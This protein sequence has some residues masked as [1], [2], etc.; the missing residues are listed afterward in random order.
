VDLNLEIANEISAKTPKP[1]S[2]APAGDAYM[3][4]LDLAGGVYAVM[5]ELV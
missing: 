2:L 5:N 4:D 3:E 1:M